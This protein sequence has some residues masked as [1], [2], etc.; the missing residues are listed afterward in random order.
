[1]AELAES[2]GESVVL[3]ILENNRCYILDEVRSA[4]LPATAFDPLYIRDLTDKATARVLL[5]HLEPAE[6]MLMLPDPAP[7]PDFAAIRGEPVHR[8]DDGQTVGLAA[9]V[10]QDSRVIAALGLYLPRQRYLEAD[11]TRFG[12]VLL[13]GT[14]QLSQALAGEG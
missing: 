10:R 5:A 2:T 13:A 3:A 8:H 1:M 14:L 9:P 7:D 12:Q 11:A 4:S 6:R